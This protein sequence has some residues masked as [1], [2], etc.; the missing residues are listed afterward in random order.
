VTQALEQKPEWNEHA[1][2]DPDLV[3]VRKLPGWPL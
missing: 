1:S 2:K 3:E